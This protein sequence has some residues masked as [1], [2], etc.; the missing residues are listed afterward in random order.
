MSSRLETGVV[1]PEGDWPGVFIRGDDSFAYSRSLRVVLAS[2]SEPSTAVSL[3]VAHLR[4]LCALLERSN[5]NGET[6]KSD[7]VREI[8]AL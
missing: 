4:G 7:E 8:I 2:M 3:S 5:V 6:Y 1:Q